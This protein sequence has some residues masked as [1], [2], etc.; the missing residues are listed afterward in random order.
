MN[1]FNRV[2]LAGNVTKDIEIR[3]TPTGTAIGNFSI[4]IN[5]KW[6]QDGEVKTE[7]SYFDIVVFGKIA[8][9]CSQY[10]GKGSAILIE[11]KLRQNVWKN[12][13]G[14]TRSKVEVIADSVNFLTRNQGDVV[15]GDDSAGNT[16]AGN[17]EEVPF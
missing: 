2:I 1:G 7:V 12:S 14:Q 3:H 4:A 15:T 10:I 17:N 9:T 5:R 16:N 8:E 13:E 6:K 11:G